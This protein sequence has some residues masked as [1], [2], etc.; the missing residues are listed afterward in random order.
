MRTSPSSSPPDGAAGSGASSSGPALTPSRRSCRL[1]I[2][3]QL[4]RR[5]HPGDPAVDQHGDCVGDIHRHAQVLLDQQHRDRVVAG[6]RLQRL[7]HLLDDDRRQPL[8]RLVH[9]QQA[10]VEQQGAGDRQHL[11]LAARELRAA[12][13]LALGQAREQVVGA[14]DG[15]RAAPFALLADRRRCSSTVSDGH[16]RRPCGTK[17]T[18]AVGDRVR[19]H[20]QDLLAQQPDAARRRHQAGDRVAQRRLAHA[21]AADHGQHAAVEGQRHVLQRVGA[22]VMDVQAVDLQ[23]RACRRLALGPVARE[24]LHW[25]FPPM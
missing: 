14:L 22:A 19:R 12:I 23:H 24:P 20:A 13:A 4:G 3:G 15:P 1:A 6:Q 8:G 18:P 17:P 25:C 5:H 9:D 11:L 10:R 16:T 2:G 7:G 21:I